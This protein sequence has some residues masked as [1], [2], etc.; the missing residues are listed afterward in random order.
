MAGPWGRRRRER[1]I[2][3]LTIPWEPGTLEAA[4]FRNGERAV[5]DRLETAGRPERI[6]LLPEQ[7]RI[8]A[9]GMDLAFVKI[10]LRDAAGRP[11]TG[12]DREVSV[13]VTGPGMSWRALA[14]EIPVRRR[15]MGRAGAQPGKAGRWPPSG[16]ERSRE[17]S[18]LP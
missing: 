11:V 3:S 18:V 12:D 5:Q 17:R 10:E 16:Q 13:T 14:P 2:A 9:D 1:F 7:Q 6:A 15:I 8:A 4:A